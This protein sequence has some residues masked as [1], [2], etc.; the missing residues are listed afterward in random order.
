M[1]S[2]FARARYALQYNGRVRKCC[3]ADARVRIVQARHP[4]LLASP[5]EVVPFD[6]TMDPEADAA[7]VGP[8]HGR[9]DGAAEGDRSDLGAL[10]QAGVIPPVGP[11]TRL[12]LF[13]RHLRGHR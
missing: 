6:L 3:R 1:D 4:L 7:R 9:Q 8:E 2:L 10:S 12:P 11:G 13:T 5:D